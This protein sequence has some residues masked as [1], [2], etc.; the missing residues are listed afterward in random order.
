MTGREGVAQAGPGR[1]PRESGDRKAGA[2]R[3]GT[4][5]W[6]VGA[7]RRS[8]VTFLLAGAAVGLVACAP[9]KLASVSTSGEDSAV[10]VRLLAFNDFHGQLEPGGLTLRL[11]DDS[12]ALRSHSV[13]GAAFLAGKLRALASERRHSLILSSGDLIGASPLASA[14]YRDEPTIEAMNAMGLG[15]NVVGNHEFDKGVDELRRLVRGGCHAAGGP[16]G[17]VAAAGASG[18]GASGAGASGAGASGAGASGAG[19]SGGPSAG[20]SA[21]STCESRDGP[22]VGAR[23]PFLAANVEDGNRGPLFAPYLIREFDGQRIAFIGVVTRTTPTI[24]SPSGVAGLRFLDEAETV[25]RY[26]SEVRAQ[27]VE[28]I[29][30][31]IHEGGAIAGDWNDPACPGARGRVFA[32][33]DRLDPA[34]DLVFSAHT[35][36]GYNCVRDAPGNAGLRIVQSHAQGRAIA[37]VDIA[38]DRR[39]RDID[40]SRTVARN[41]PVLNKADEAGSSPVVDRQVAAIVD[42][43]AGLAQARAGRPVGSILQTFDR[44]GRRGGDSAAGRLVADAQLAATRAA[45]RGGAVLAFTNPG[46]V[47]TDLRCIGT[48]PCP[49][50]YGQVFAT[51]PFGNHLVVMTLTGAQLK[52]LLEQ[53]FTGV[54]AA[55]PRILQPSAGFS[56]RYRA[57][58][59]DGARVSDMRLDGRPVDP[60]GRYRVTVNAFLA[61]GGDGFGVLLEGSERLGG[62]QDVDALVAYLSAHSP[63]APDRS[64]RVIRED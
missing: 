18:A 53:Q 17:A 34:V 10:S 1:D 33:A 5:A 20:G 43:Y 28:A 32:I 7:A 21:F 8:L 25:N 2:F 27:G 6:V 31:V 11:R 55:S 4:C 14:L 63:L 50:S 16:A 54:N 23:F 42:H 37:L 46:G 13:G 57:G 62:P 3:S 26:V 22:Y 64:L 51:Q 49:V 56:Y 24:V 41:L 30:V 52:A 39:T 44:E 35:H 47:R 29:A 61:D 15:L 58:A 48:P 59:A 38:I 60:S 36:Q 12:G 40:R 45:E 19:A 9:G